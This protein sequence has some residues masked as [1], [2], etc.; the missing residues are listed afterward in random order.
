MQSQPEIIR[1]NSRLREVRAHFPGRATQT[2][3]EVE[4]LVQE[5]YAEGWEAGQK[6]LSS[7]LVQ[8]RADLLHLQNGVIASMKQAVHGVIA[9]TEDIL[10]ALVLDSVRKIIGESA[11]NLETV[12][13]V[14]KE[15]LHGVAHDCVFELRLH[16]DDLVLFRQVQGELALS[17]EVEIREDTKL[18]R[19]DC[20]VSTRF[21]TIDARRST[22]L[23]N[24]QKA[25]SC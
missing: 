1:F 2:S 14:V 12:E 16:P 3:S 18:E 19:G 5:G 15:A 8:Q 25:L 13:G 10:R 20:I 24:L 23:N 21:G 17:N 11:I 7:Q 22:K 4:A 6:V 9:E